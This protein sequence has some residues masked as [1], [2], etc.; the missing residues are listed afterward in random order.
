MNPK[1]QRVRQHLHEYTLNYEELG[2]HLYGFEPPGLLHLVVDD[3]LILVDALV[4]GSRE[5]HILDKE[6][7]TQQYLSEPH[8]H[9]LVLAQL[10]Y[11]VTI[12][13][14]SYITE[15]KLFRQGL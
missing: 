10:Q 14:S 11:I 1:I 7:E 8:S 5:D 3:R 12:K 15:G 2:S 4:S 9:T 13:F 6:E